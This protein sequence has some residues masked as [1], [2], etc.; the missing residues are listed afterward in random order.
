M[1]GDTIY[2]EVRGGATLAFCRDWRIRARAVENV[3]AEYAAA[4][5]G[6]GFV[7]HARDRFGG[8]I[9]SG[10]EPLGWK[11]HRTPCRDGTYFSKP[12][13]RGEGAAEGKAFQ[14]EIDAL[15]P[16][17]ADDE[18]LP[19]IGFPRSFDYTK[20]G[21][22]GTGSVS[23]GFST[24]QIAWID[25]GDSFWI[26]LPDFAKRVAVMQERG[27][28]VAPDSWSAP[29][30][31]KPSSRARYELAQAAAKVALEEAA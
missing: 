11:R 5:A 31:M 30:G 8:V 23:Q 16:L 15:P 20:A 25:E 29:E 26:V 6:V 27:Y 1:F 22:S 13:K 17:P 19:I 10:D 12:V 21:K 18:V 9:F 14:V 7:R 28:T 2:Y 4:K 3:Y 24:A